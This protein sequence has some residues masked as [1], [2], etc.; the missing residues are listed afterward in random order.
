MD[1][2][3]H[4]TQ[5]PI[6]QIRGV[7]LAIRE[8]S[9]HQRH[10][11]ILYLDSASKEILFLHLAWHFDLRHETPNDTYLW[12]DPAL[13]ARRL[14]Q[15]AAVCR[16]V[17]RANGQ[18]RIPYGFGPSHAC[19]DQESG[20]YLFGP[21]GF[22]L[23]CAT[24]VFAVFTRAGLELAHYAT[25]P[26]DRPG[27][28]D[29]QNAIVDELRK[30]STATDEHIHAVENDIGTMARFRPEEVAGAAIAASIPASFQIAEERSRQ[31]LV[32]LGNRPDQ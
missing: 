1:R 21:T 24:F 18:A 12:V 16:Q 28:R 31:I 29:W 8:T 30:R 11:G 17:W 10:I 14:V 13:P 23:T 32:R 7:G 6:S 3:Y 2:V 4:A 25:W 22:G 5:R 26:L 20:K 15:V 19:L 27:D 9:P